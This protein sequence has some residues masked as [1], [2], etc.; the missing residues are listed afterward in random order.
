MNSEGPDQQRL[1][2]RARERNICRGFLIAA[3]LLVLIELW[4]QRK[5][6]VSCR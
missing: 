5:S 3:I 4:Q 6:R 2:L 1:V